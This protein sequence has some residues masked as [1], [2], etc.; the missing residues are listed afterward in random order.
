M[1]FRGARRFT[2]VDDW[3]KHKN[4]GRNSNFL[5]GWK[6]KPGFCEV[7]L[8]PSLLPM[9]IYRH[10][11]P[12]YVLVKDKDDKNKEITRVFSKKYLCHETEETLQNPWREKETDR[13]REYPP[14]R[15]GICKGSDWFW[16]QIKDW[17]D[18]HE[19]NDDDKQWVETRKGK[20]KGLDPLAILFEF[21]S[22]YD[23]DENRTVRVG[24]FCGYFAK[25]KLEQDVKDACKKA[26]Y[27]LDEQYKTNFSPRCEYAMTVVDNND[28]DKGL[29][30]AVESQ[31]LGQ[32]TCEVIE[33]QIEGAGRN[34]QKTPYCIKWSYYPKKD[35]KEKYDAMYM[36]LIKPSARI[37]K[38]L[39]GEAPD[40]PEDLTKPFNQQA[41]K[42]MFEEHCLI[43]G[44]PWDDFFPTKEQ[45]AEWAKQDA[46]DAA[47]DERLQKSAA[48]DN[49]TDEVPDSGDEAA[50]D[51]EEE[52]SEVDEN[53]EEMFSCDNPKC[54]KPTRASDKKC[55]HC[56][57]KFDSEDGGDEEEEEEEEEEEAPPLRTRADAKKAAAAAKAKEEKAPPKTAANGKK[58]ANGTAGKKAKAPPAKGSD[59]EMGA[60]QGEDEDGI[61]F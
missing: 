10:N 16:N 38:L 30:V 12:T 36:E 34:I 46:E 28:V 49:D 13:I 40:Y 23:D 60:D 33:K 7:F 47:E 50:A 41:L 1:A 26:K 3:L 20:G 21:E 14:E 54:G 37:M 59:A 51:S 17:L 6:E 43:K 27:R 52:E 56:G 5:G 32:A 45:E 19:W 24:D 61:P 55:P 29:R 8:H 31:A 4:R 35:F 9:A 48:A 44:I 15:C 18:T 25:K 22:E 53:G 57:M 58:G 42:S 11:I 39:K 2:S